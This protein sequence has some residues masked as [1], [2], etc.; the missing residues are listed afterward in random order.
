MAPFI[1]S[2]NLENT[3]STN[4]GWSVV[5]PSAIA[6]HD[7]D[8]EATELRN[9]KISTSLSI[10]N[11]GSGSGSASASASAS[12]SDSGSDASET[13]SET[14]NVTDAP[15]VESTTRKFDISNFQPELQGG[16]RPIYKTAATPTEKP[17]RSDSSID[18]LVYD[19]E[20][21]E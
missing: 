7:N 21:I 14:T 12:G 8:V 16:F 3:Q 2:V 1:P 10:Q 13:S 9:N 15:T 11:D 20:E 18:A 5:T 4:N 17:E 6:H 19:D